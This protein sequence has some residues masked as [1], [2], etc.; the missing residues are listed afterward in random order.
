MALVKSTLEVRDLELLAKA[1]LEA[2]T[3]FGTS[4]FWRGHADAEWALQAH[5]FRHQ[6][7]RLNEA[8]MLLQFVL[9]GRPRASSNAPP[10]DDRIGWIHLAQHYGLPTRLLDWTQSPFVALYFAVFERSRNLD[11]TDGCLWSLNPV[12][13]NSTIAD[14]KGILTPDHSKAAAVINEAFQDANRNAFSGR[15]LAIGAFANDLR[16]VVQQSVF[17]VHGDDLDLRTLDSASEL[18]RQFI[19]PKDSK[20]FIRD[21]LRE[22][23]IKY[24]FLFPDLAGLARSIREECD[25]S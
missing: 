9:G 2:V 25:P 10:R 13:L 17:T 5:V 8:S 14:V 6:Q 7:L 21:R 19:I 16:M 1:S 3:A 18:L 4:P 24:S 12:A 15:A 11:E 20:P 22:V 23:G